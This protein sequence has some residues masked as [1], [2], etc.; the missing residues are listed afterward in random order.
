MNKHRPNKTDRSRIRRKIRGAVKT[1][2]A[3]G[4]GCNHRGLH[5]S[6]TY[7]SIAMTGKS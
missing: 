1:A 3:S 7:V 4:Q 6:L 5:S 2:R